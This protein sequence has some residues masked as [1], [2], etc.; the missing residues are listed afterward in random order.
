M[1]SR[2]GLYQNKVNPAS[3]LFKGEVTK[4][5]TVK[6]VSMETHTLPKFQPTGF[7]QSRSLSNSSFNKT[8]LLTLACQVLLCQQ[9][10]SHVT[11]L[12]RCAIKLFYCVLHGLFYS[13]NLPAVKNRIK[14]RVCEKESN[15]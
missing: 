7:A 13:S 9:Y 15:R 3:L 5:T 12:I 1:K 2:L 11:L 10:V 8:W 4:R 6:W 14:R